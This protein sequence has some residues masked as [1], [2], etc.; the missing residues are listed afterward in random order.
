MLPL[1]Q[2]WICGSMSEI[3][4]ADHLT[5]LFVSH[6]SPDNRAG[7]DSRSG[8]LWAHIT[9]QSEPVR[10][11]GFSGIGV[12]ELLDSFTQAIAETAGSDGRPVAYIGLHHTGG[13]VS[14]TSVKVY[15][16]YRTG[17]ERTGGQPGRVT[18]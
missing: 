1:S 11:D 8:V 14:I 15:D 10:I 3:V 18:T 16:S 4:R 12:G 2:I 13:Q 9:G 7:E 5:S 17:V 6:G